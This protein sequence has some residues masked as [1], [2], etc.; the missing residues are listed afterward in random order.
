MSGYYICDNEIIYTNLLSKEEAE[1]KLEE[2]SKIL[3]NLEIK[4]SED[5]LH[6][7]KVNSGYLI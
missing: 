3:K 6:M 2:F 5:T 7:Q 4:S 1:K